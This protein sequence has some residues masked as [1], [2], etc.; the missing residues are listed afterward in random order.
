MFILLKESSAG[1]IKLPGLPI[2]SFL[3]NYVA[4]VY[5]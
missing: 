4:G 2:L 5:Y 3:Y 1:E